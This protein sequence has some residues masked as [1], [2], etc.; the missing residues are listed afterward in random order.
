MTSSSPVVEQPG[1]LV[2]KWLR[3]AEIDRAVVFI[4]LTRVW[5]I[6]AAPVTLLLIVRYFSPEMQGYY[7]TLGSL[8]ALQTF[9]ELNLQL[10][11]V[12]VVSHEWSHLELDAD[13]RIVGD[14]RALSRLVSIGRLIFKWYAVAA[15]LFVVTVS[16]GGYI[17]V[18]ASSR[19]A[20]HYWQGPWLAWVFLT[21]LTLWLLPFNALLEGCNQLAAVNRL[22]LSQAFF[23]SL[24]LWLTI[25]AGG[26]LWAGVAAATIVVLR[27]AYML[28]VQFR[29]FF[30]PF[31]RFPT[32]EVVV[33]STEIWPMQW[34]LAVSGVCQYFAFSLF[35]PVMFSAHGAVVA[36]QMGISMTAVSAIQ[37]LAASWV[38]SRVPRFGALIAKRKY[39]ELDHLFVRVCS[40]AC[41]VGAFGALAFWLIVYELNA[42]GHPYARR[43]LAPLPIGLFLFGSVLMQVAGCLSSYLRAHKR[44]PFAI[45]SL[46]TSTVL[47][48]LVWLLGTRYGPI[49]AAVSYLG[50]WAFILV[51]VSVVFVRLRE[52][53]H[54][55]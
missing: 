36:G 24:V 25:S 52:E 31:Y 35:N 17:F 15:S 55:D 2:R 8:L 45:L 46:V 19:S 4:V 13:G 32:R 51:A 12:S 48:L 10:V 47:G 16:I 28:L 44:E 42:L 40:I 33:W 27:D 5:Q 1:G 41:G 22:R 50:V 38:T 30:E 7:Y 14:P 43:F 34:R 37:T 23:S 9:F 53:W 54:R 49:G 18:S 20:V 29:K 21:G 11:I 26:G 3:R 6:L 39:E